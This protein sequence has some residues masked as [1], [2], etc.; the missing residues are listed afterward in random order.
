MSLLADQA[1]RVRRAYADG[2]GVDIAAFATEALT[3]VDRLEPAP[4]PYVAIAATFGTG[5][6]LSI[7]PAYREAAT[8]LVPR[9]HHEAAAPTFLA[10]IAA[11]ARSRGHHPGVQGASI[12][13]ALSRAPGDPQPPAGLRFVELDAD[14]MKAGIAAGGFANGF[15]LGAADGRDFRNRFA[16][17]AL[18]DAGATVGVAGV[19]LTFGLHEIGIDVLRSE[20]GHGLAPL[21]V[22]AAAAAILARGE[23]PF[24]GCGATNIRSQ[25][26]ALAAGFVPV[27]SD[28][29][30]G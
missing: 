29:N 1:A 18:D 28:A 26:T 21:L 4:W 24:Y 17:A 5:T 22:R 9:T 12:G 3:V 13:W 25:R 7:D 27:C 23:T 11:E 10:A 8:A 14:A 2:L 19:F 16:I 20:R 6:V 30:V 15:G